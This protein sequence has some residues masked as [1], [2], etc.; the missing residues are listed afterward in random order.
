MHAL[1]NKHKRT[2]QIC[3]AVIAIVTVY[4]NVVKCNRIHSRNHVLS[5]DKDRFLEDTNV[6]ILKVIIL[7]Q[8]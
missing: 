6:K 8:P 7:Y 3:I 2:P 1:K 4:H 5:K